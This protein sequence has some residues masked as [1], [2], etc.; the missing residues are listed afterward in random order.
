MDLVDGD[1]DF[2][3]IFSSDL[4]TPLYVDVVLGSQRK[5]KEV[6]GDS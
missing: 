5:A 3:L 6:Y 2:R 4:A 1:T